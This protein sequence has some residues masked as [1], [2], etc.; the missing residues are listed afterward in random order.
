MSSSSAPNPSG[1]CRL[2][3]VRL[4]LVSPQRVEAQ[5]TI[6]ADHL[7]PA[8]LLHGGVT[9]LVSEEVAS[10]AAALNVPSGHSVVGSRITLNH[11]RSAVAGDVVTVAATPVHIGRM[12]HLWQVRAE[13]QGKEGGDSQL[14]SIGDMA[15]FVIQPRTRSKL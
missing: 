13:K 7:Q 1:P 9:A 15:A 12:T 10:T 8:G 5:Y 4:T 3:G 2:L 11:L 6:T 14:L